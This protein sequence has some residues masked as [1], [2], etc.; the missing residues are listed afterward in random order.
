MYV[1]DTSEL[2][3]FNKVLLLSS[4]MK[5][6]PYQD[7]RTIGHVGASFSNKGLRYYLTE[8]ILYLL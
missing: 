5:G 1:V 6:T 3:V 4:M 2:P 7:A 8:G